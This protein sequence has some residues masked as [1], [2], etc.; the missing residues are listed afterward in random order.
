MKGEAMHQKD[1]LRVRAGENAHVIARVHTEGLWPLTG[2]DST[3]QVMFVFADRGQIELVSDSGPV[4]LSERELH[5][6]RS[7]RWASA[8]VPKGSRM[9]VLRMT[10]DC[11]GSE[12]SRMAGS[13]V[14]VPAV[15]GAM[16]GLV[17]HVLR[18]L[19]SDGAGSGIS[20]RAASHISGLLALT[21]AEHFVLSGSRAGVSLFD[22]ARAY[23]ELNLG[24]TS[25]G[26]DRVAGALNVS[27]RTLA[28]AFREHGTTVSACIREDR[29]DRCYAELIDERMLSLAVSRIGARWGLPD[30]SH[31]SHMFKA[32]FGLSPRALRD[33]FSTMERSRVTA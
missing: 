19:V 21:I 4:R 12:L 32:R 3:P 33:Q 13:D 8:L 24:D 15:G 22:E 11:A 30:P 29:L 7:G 20:E 9:I 2:P 27:T 23:M 18:G 5:V 14:L 26:Q 10:R 16:P 25:L 28:R 6:S 17:G 1:S 31:F